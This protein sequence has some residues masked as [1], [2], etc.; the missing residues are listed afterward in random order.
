MGFGTEIF[1]FVALG[2]LVFGPKRLHTMLG[3]ITR[4]K[5]RLE[6]IAQAFKSQ[7]VEELD[8]ERFS[9]APRRSSE[10]ADR[11]AR[12]PVAARM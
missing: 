12:S 7:L 8:S 2:V 6:E 3:H 1:F 10:T 9:T 5:I 11:L 4:A